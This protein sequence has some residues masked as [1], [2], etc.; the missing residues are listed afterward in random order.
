MAVWCLTAY[1]TW[2]VADPQEFSACIKESCYVLIPAIFTIGY[3]ADHHC[4]VY[5]VCFCFK[6]RFFFL[7]FFLSTKKAIGDSS[8]FKICVY[9]LFQMQLSMVFYSESGLRNNLVFTALEKKMMRHSF[10]KQNI[11]VLHL[12]PFFFQA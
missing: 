12:K 2:A 8:C 7:F 10:K 4:Q 5:A 3:I 11:E 6:P 1:S 9:V